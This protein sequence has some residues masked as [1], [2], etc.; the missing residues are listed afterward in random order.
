VNIPGK[1]NFDEL[2]Q[3]ILDAQK[4]LQDA[5]ICESEARSRTTR[6]KNKYN[7]AGKA[8]DKAVSDAKKEAPKN[9]DFR[10]NLGVR[11]RQEANP[12]D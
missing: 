9:T 3:N 7:E 12:N 6:A 5:E 10:L 4:E 2:Y 8:F 11:H 1:Y